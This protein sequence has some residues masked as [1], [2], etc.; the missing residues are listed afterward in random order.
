MIL[1]YS[2]N[3]HE[4]RIVEVVVSRAGVSLTSR[5]EVQLGRLSVK[6]KEFAL[7]LIQILP[8]VI[9]NFAV[10]QESNR[11]RL[12]CYYEKEFVRSISVLV[13]SEASFAA[14]DCNAGLGGYARSRSLS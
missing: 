14:S 10:H 12:V 1:R 4:H 8:E 13:N 2:Q 3:S 7:R 9:L 6:H 5:L 11:A